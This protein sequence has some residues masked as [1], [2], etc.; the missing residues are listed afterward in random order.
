MTSLLDL[1]L[2]HFKQ[3]SRHWSPRACGHTIM[4]MGVQKHITD[5]SQMSNIKKTIRDA[6]KPNT[7]YCHSNPT[8]YGESDGLK[9][10][11]LFKIDAHNTVEAVV[12]TEKNTK[13][14]AFANVA[15]LWIVSFALLALLGLSEI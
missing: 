14:C 7:L 2:P 3:S 12:L 4:G 10:K 13:P 6:P 1:T 8:C 5:Y 11:Y 15:A 9:I